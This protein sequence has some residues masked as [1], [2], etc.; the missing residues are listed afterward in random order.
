MGFE[1]Q[2]WSQSDFLIEAMPDILT[3]V[4]PDEL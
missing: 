3:K 4:K 1:Y 2:A